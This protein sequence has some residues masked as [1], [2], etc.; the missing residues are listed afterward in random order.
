[1]KTKIYLLMTTLIFFSCV[2]S[3]YVTEDNNSKEKEIYV[4]DDVSNVDTTKI[5]PEE[6]KPEQIYKKE[7]VIPVEKTKT[8]IKFTVQVGAFT[9][10]ERAE[11][12]INQNQNKTSFPL[13]IFYN[14][15]TKL[16]SVQIPPYSTKE[17]ADK[18]RDILKNFPPFKEAFTIQI[19]K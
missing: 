1:M 13:K 5:Q 19:E 10:K 3:E 11:Q 2:S 16:Y 18:I 9:S 12:F 7:E 15:N 17:E 14:Q 6:K 8:E 4:F